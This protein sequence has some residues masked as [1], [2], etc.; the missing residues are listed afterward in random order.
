MARGF[1]FDSWSCPPSGEQ[2]MK[3]QGVAEQN[4]VW[5][6][7][8]P[9]FEVY[10]NCTPTETDSSHRI[11]QYVIRQFAGSETRERVRRFLLGT[12]DPPGQDCIAPSTISLLQQIPPTMRTPSHRCDNST[13]PGAADCNSNLYQGFGELLLESNPGTADNVVGHPNTDAY[14]NGVQHRR[15]IRSART[16]TAVPNLH[17]P[18]APELALRIARLYTNVEACMNNPAGYNVYGL[19]TPSGSAVGYGYKTPGSMRRRPLLP[20]MAKGCCL[21]PMERV[22]PDGKQRFDYE[23]L[24]HVVDNVARGG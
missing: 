19:V 14:I 2:P 21:S 13:N 6:N 18:G 10:P 8:G 23:A 9:G 7:G 24:Q 17:R 16:H 5:G 4:V 1:V 3:Y 15:P 12:W 11:Q 22:G 20:D